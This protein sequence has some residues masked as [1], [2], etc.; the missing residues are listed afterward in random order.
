MLSLGKPAGGQ[1]TD[2]IVVLTGGAGRV[3][4]GLELMEAGAAKRMLISGADTT[5]RPNE[6]AHEYR[7]PR[8]LFACCIDLGYEAVDTRSNAEETATWLAEHGYTSVRLV[9]TEWHMPRAH[10]ELAHAMTTDV[11]VIGDAI[12]S[13]PAFGM[14]VREYNKYLVRRVALWLGY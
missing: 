2:A 5:V 11:T 7:V 1:K 12:P 6:L 8:R 13:N 10:M 3:A 9:T 4:R 14:L